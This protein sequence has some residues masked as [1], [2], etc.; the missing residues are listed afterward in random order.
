ME[1]YSIRQTARQCGHV[2][3]SE[4]F[5]KWLGLG[6]QLGKLEEAKILVEAQNSTGTI[7]FTM[8]KVVVTR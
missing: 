5:S 2:S 4:H 1:F 6:L 3:I 7:D 8:A